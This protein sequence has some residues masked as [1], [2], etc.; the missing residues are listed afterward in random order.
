MTRAVRKNSSPS[1]NLEGN[2]IY[3]LKIVKQI[4]LL[5]LSQVEIFF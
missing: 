1:L 2:I 4:E 3:A 5:S